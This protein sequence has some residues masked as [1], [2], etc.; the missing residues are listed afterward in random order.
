MKNLRLVVNGAC[1]L[2]AVVLL[3]CLAKS[4][5]F[6]NGQNNIGALVF[7]RDV[8]LQK[9]G[10]SDEA[11]YQIKG[12]SIDKNSGSTLYD[13]RFEYGGRVGDVTFLYQDN[14]F[15]LLSLENS[16]SGAAQK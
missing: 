7:T 12:I 14:K 4:F 13:V 15:K 9:F 1:G 8:L 2:L 3:I 6:P 16:T 10:P 11:S 5:I